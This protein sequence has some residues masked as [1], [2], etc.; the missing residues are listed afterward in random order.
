MTTRLGEAGGIF[1]I[2]A[3]VHFVAD[4]VFQS[5][6]TAMTKHRNARVRAWHCWWYVSFFIVP[7]SLLD[8]GPHFA[9]TLLETGILFWSHFIE[10]TYLPVY[11]WAK[12]IR[13]AVNDQAEFGVFIETTLG[14]ILMIVIDQVI[15]L[16]F[17]WPVIWLI[18]RAHGQG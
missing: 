6:A 7:L 14:K 10:D 1:A 17:L 11:L 15:H 4:W 12:Y 9:R 5:H 16:A 2:L 18:L 13:R 8:P 3:L